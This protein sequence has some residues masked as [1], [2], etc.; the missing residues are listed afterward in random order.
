M[1]TP[2]ATSAT[3][4]KNSHES[5]ARFGTR[6]IALQEYVVESDAPYRSC[7]YEQ[8]RR[9]RQ[10]WR[11]AARS[12]PSVGRTCRAFV[13]VVA[14]L[15]KKFLRRHPSR[16]IRRSGRRAPGS[17]GTGRSSRSPGTVTPRPQADGPT[18]GRGVTVPGLRELRPVPRLPG[19]RRPLRRIGR[20]GWRRRNFLSKDATTTTNE[21][22]VRPTDGGEGRAPPALTPYQTHRTLGRFSWF[23]TV[24][25]VRG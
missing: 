25:L 21:R 13:V 4:V 9:L 1:T 20:E 19:A 8:L 7:R 14:S 17:R 24:A 3:T 16:P 18:W 5:G 11:G 6:S 12:P 2:M 23:E 15:L 10:G 22:Q